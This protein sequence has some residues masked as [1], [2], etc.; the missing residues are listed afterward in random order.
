MLLDFFKIKTATDAK[1]SLLKTISW[2]IIG[3]IVTIIIAY[4][5]TGKIDVALGIGSFEAIAKMVFYY[6]HERAWVKLLK[7]K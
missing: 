1:V 5:F 7:K 3:T 4:F 6:L 2:R